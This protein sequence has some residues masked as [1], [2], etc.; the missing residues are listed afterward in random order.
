[1]GYFLLFPETEEGLLIMELVESEMLPELSEKEQ[2]P[3]TNTELQSAKKNS[4]C[5]KLFEYKCIVFPIKFKQHKGN[6]QK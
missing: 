5:F 4:V 6:A 2:P 3:I 1:L